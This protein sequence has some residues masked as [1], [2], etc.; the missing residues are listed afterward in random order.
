MDCL[1]PVIQIAQQHTLE[2]QLTI[3]N[4]HTRTQY[5]VLILSDV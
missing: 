4:V 5:Q 1:T 3:V 2:E